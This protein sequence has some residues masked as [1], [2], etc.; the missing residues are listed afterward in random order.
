MTIETLDMAQYIVSR[1]RKS[2]AYFEDLLFQLI[3]TVNA[4]S[5][6]VEDLETRVTA[7][8]AFHP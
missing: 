3:D 6:T 8:E 5:V 1:E 4:L 7:L 2:T